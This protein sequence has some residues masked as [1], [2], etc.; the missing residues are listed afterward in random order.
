VDGAADLVSAP[1]WPPTDIFS[2]WT[3]LDGEPFPVSSALG[4][5]ARNFGLV[6]LVPKR[7][8]AHIDDPAAVGARL[9]AARERAGLTQ[10]E[11]SFEGCTPAYI[12]RVEAGKRIP[13]LQ[14]LREFANRLGVDVDYLASGSASRPTL[15]LLDAELEVKLGD[16]QAA[17]E[18]YGSLRAT[19]RAG[20]AAARAELGLG[21]AALAAG[22]TGEAVE[23]LERLVG[24]GELDA[25]D[26][27]S[28]ADALGRAYAL[29]GDL[30]AAIALFE[31]HL[32]RAQEDDDL[33]EKIRFSILLANALVDA[34]NGGR[35]SEVLADVLDEVQ[36][37]PDRIAR[38]ALLWTRSRLHAR[39]EQ[40]DLAEQY[41]QLARGALR[42]GEQEL[43]EAELHE[44]AAHIENDRA[45]PL[46][47]LELLDRGEPAV[48]AS[49]NR[50]HTALFEIERARA[51]LALGEPEQAATLAADAARAL[52]ETSPEDAGRAY[53]LLGHVFRDLGETER[54][55]EVY[56]LAGEM[57][58]AAHGRSRVEVY[59]AL[60]DIFEARGDTK[61]ALEA[62]RTALPVRPRT[63]A[64]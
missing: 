27:A 29:R 45:E 5:V 23:R 38:A 31:R 57:L 52:A 47:A 12:S 41:A 42:L 18:A 39:Q 55:I 59:A 56:E 58:G 24:S 11:L 35:A 48:R 64:T 36:E 19:M 30:E 53:A 7:P 28:A 1:I 37:V 32:A 49:G 54:A 26:R 3:A 6:A 34:G 8:G 15:D 10:R 50:V 43:H 51:L 20:V 4:I 25:A 22:E 40:L 33:P 2:L 14:I 44:L 13:S 63:V 17:K 46:R 21:L 9:R 61:A 16:P 60:A 62:L